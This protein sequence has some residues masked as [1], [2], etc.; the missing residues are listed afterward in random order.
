MQKE[1]LNKNFANTA[2]VLFNEGFA[3]TKIVVDESLHM[4]QQERY[5]NEFLLVT[6]GSLKS[7]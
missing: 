7:N 5:A 4:L 2:N 3:M 1:E 6:S